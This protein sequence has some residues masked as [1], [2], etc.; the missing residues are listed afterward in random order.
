M[1]EDG[2]Q[3]EINSVDTMIL[4]FLPLGEIISTV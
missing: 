2:Q 4:D 3:E 1:E